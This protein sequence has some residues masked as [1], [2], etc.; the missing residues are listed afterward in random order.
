MSGN[1]APGSTLRVSYLPKGIVLPVEDLAAWA[2]DFVDG[3]PSGIREMEAM[4]QDLARR[5][6]EAVGVPVRAVADLK[7]DP[8]V[9]GDQQTMR[10]TARATLRTVSDEPGAGWKLAP[11]EPTEAMIQIG[12]EAARTENIRDQSLQGRTG[13]IYRAMLL[14]APDPAMPD[15]QSR[16]G[17]V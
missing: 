4:I 2:R 11:T 14:A 15:T 7:I 8:P 6:A 16:E 5:T 13:R 17:E 10:V 9:P 3:H 1:P 12:L